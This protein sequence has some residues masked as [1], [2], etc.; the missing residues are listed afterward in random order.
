M[1]VKMGE[2]IRAIVELKKPPKLQFYSVNCPIT[3]L[4]ERDCLEILELTLP[5]SRHRMCECI[6]CVN[7]RIAWEMSIRGLYMHKGPHINAE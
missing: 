1:H 6:R 2:I 5:A 3:R 7:S 4:I